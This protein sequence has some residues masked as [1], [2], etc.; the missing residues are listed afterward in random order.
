VL[1]VLFDSWLFIF[2][3]GVLV[4]GVGLSASRYTC[5]LAIYACISFYALS[6]VLI[7]AFLVEKVYV[8]WS[9]GQQIPRFTSPAYR[10]SAFV[11]LGYVVVLILMIM[12]ENSSIRPDGLCVIGLKN[13]ATIPLISYDLFLNVFLTAMF[14]WPL[15]RSKVVNH[16]LK[17]IATRTLVGAIVSLTTSAANVAVLTVLKGTEY[18]WLCLGSCVTDVALNALALSWVTAKSSYSIQTI[19]VDQIP[20][21]TM[22]TGPFVHVQSDCKRRTAHD[23]CLMP[24]LSPTQPSELESNLSYIPR[25]PGHS[26]ADIVSRSDISKGGFWGLKEKWRP[27]RGT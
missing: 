25:D 13:Y 20:L 9:A 3:T 26:D 1:L 7:Y 22:D 16:R 8:V 11:M 24:P 18:G 10:I 27:V 17:K 14:V 19:T 4:N 2:F 15:W 6:K 12:G 23:D 21:P 5:A